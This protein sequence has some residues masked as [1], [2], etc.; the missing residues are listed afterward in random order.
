MCILLLCVFWV[1][2]TF[3]A[4]EAAGPAYLLSVYEEHVAAFRA[5]EA[6]PME[7]FETKTAF[8]PPEEAERLKR[9]IPA[10]DE[11]ALQRLIEDY[12]S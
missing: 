2:A 1:G 8:L 6:E 3:A 4:R 11:K 12:C 9:G 7:I 5:G 10:A